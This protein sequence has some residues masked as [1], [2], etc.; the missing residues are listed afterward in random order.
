LIPFRHAFGGHSSIFRQ[1][2]LSKDSTVYAFEDAFLD[3][4][5]ADLGRIVD[6]GARDKIFREIGDKLFNDIPTIP[7]V[8]L[9][10][11]IMVDPKVVAEYVFTGT[12][13]GFYTHLEY[14]KL[15]K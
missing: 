11:D 4:K 5:W 15:A 2:Y 9:F 6:P 1:F 13:T 14:I 12:Y 8:W 10:A 3:Q 7:L